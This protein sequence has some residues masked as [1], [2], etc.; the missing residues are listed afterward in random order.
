MKVYKRY[1]ETYLFALPKKMLFLYGPRQSGK[2]TTAKKIIKQKGGSYFNWDDLTVRREYLKNPRFLYDYIKPGKDNIFV[3]DEIHKLKNWKNTLKGIYDEFS[4]KCQIIVTGSARLDTFLKAGDSLAG[5]YFGYKFNP[6]GVSEFAQKFS[7]IENNA[8]PL[9]YEW[10]EKNFQ[11][12]TNGN[13]KI[14]SSFENL[15]SLTAFPEPLI[16]NN[17]RFVNKW[18]NDYIRQISRED[19]QTLAAIENITTIENLMLLLP[20]RLSSPLQAQSIADD[21]QISYK[22]VVRYI[23]LL[24]RV[25]LIFEVPPYNK[26]LARAIK[27]EK[28]IY[29]YDYSLAVNEGSRFENFIA[30]NILMY[31]NRLNDCGIGSYSLHFLKDKD[32]HEVDFIIANKTKPLLLIEVKLSETD[33]SK[34]AHYWINKLNIPF[35]Q[36]VKNLDTPILKQNNAMIL[37]AAGYLQYLT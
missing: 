31:V 32:G 27:K 33:L 13:K 15:Y 21:L 9:S 6:F 23:D 17:K 16:S 36:L 20:E 7:V 3:F 18:S 2:T 25:F 35:I 34:S 26:S 22:T 1:I 14:K 19:I 4:D 28:K 24:K 37:P 29:F 12:I 10:I 5:R 8:S 30:L 11:Y